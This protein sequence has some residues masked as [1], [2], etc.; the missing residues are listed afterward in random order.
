MDDLVR[1]KAGVGPGRRSKDCPICQKDIGEDERVVNHEKCGD[2]MCESSLS[3]RVKE[4]KGQGVAAN[5]PLCSAVILEGPV[6]RV[7]WED[8]LE[9]E[10]GHEHANGGGD[11]TANDGIWGLEGESEGDTDP[12]APAPYTHHEPDFDISQ[13]QPFS[14]ETI[15][16][17]L[18]SL[19][20]T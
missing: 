7:E 5:F 19:E 16:T 6:K 13:Y 11:E 14:S 15:A 20:P 10:N 9:L 1:C 8:E 3:A 2:T 12:G 4:K 18:A 17:R